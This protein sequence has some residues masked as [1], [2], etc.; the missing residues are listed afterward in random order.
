MRAL[1]VLALIAALAVVAISSGKQL[2]RAETRGDVDVYIHGARLI[3]AGEHLYESPEPRGG[4]YYTN[5]PSLAV[6]AM[7]LAF[8]PFAVAVVGWTLLSVACAAW[9]VAGFYRAMTGTP[10]SAQPTRARWIVGFFAILLTL[11]ALLYHL[12]LGQA[13][14]LAAAIAVAGLVLY[15]GGREL[16]GGFVLGLSIVVKIITLPLAIPFAIRPRAALGIACGAAVGLAAPAV[17]LGFDRNLDFLSYFL[18]E[19]VLRTEDLRRTRY[20]PL[21]MNY[22]LAGQ[23]YRFFGDVTAFEHDGRLYSVTIARLPDAALIAAGKLVAPVVGGTILL[24]AWIFRKRERFVGVWGAVALAFC[25]APVFSLL[26]HKHYY[27]MLLPAHLYV[28]YLWY[29]RQLRD[30]W[31]RGLVV[32]S[33]IV[34]I[35]STTLFDFVGALMSNLGGLVWG[36]TLLAAAIWRAAAIGNRQS[37]M[38]PG[39]V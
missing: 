22:S 19:I 37:A 29:V 2:R 38:T 15:A 16:A 25:L 30:R 14:L 3:L 32:A 39:W 36:A 9:I 12:D 20:W 31:F 26:S 24:Y 18:E 1:A 17:V 35:L 11:R 33:F 5:L 28:V 21:N 13:N 8:V 7:P 34:A 23:L 4:Q 10:L 27:V 6:L